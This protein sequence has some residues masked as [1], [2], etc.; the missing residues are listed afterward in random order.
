MFALLRRDVVVSLLSGAITVE[1]FYRELYFMA[2]AVTFAIFTVSLIADVAGFNGL[3]IVLIP[4]WVVIVG[5]LGFHPRYITLAL[6]AGGTLSLGPDVSRQRII[7]GFTDGWEKWKSFLL[8]GAMFGG[9]FFL[10]RFLIPI[11][12]NPFAGMIM[13]GALLTLG[14]WN[15]KYADT[16]SHWYKH[17]VLYLALLSLTIGVFG[18]IT[19]KPEKDEHPLAPI[20]NGIKGIW[21]DSFY[22]KTLE[23][24]VST[25]DPQRLC[26]VRPGKRKFE[27][28]E[29]TYVLI[30]GTNFDLTSFIRVNDV[31][32]QE[33]FLV[34]DDG[35]VDISYALDGNTKF[36][37]QFLRIKF[38]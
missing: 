12:D 37:P 15:W 22:S 4:V 20:S 5:Y 28:P 27:I 32:P 1:D 14:L 35:C 34:G 24:K 6:T 10:T 17:Y 9:A 38:S 31:L 11:H 33:N 13:V 25:L 19:G 16:N 30:E 18:T 21:D 8:H 36:A 23:L 3:N 26:G 2:I 29:T 7:K